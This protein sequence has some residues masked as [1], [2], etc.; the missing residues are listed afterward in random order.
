MKSNVVHAYLG[1]AVNSIQKQPLN[2]T[3]LIND[4][5]VKD[6]T[7]VI[8]SIHCIIKAILC[9]GCNDVEHISEKIFDDFQSD[10]CSTHLL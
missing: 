1:S 2:I 6:P 3:S 4:T 9:S 10:K 7:S 5:S 8:Y